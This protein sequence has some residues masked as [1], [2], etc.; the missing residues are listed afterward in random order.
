MI[1]S[2]TDKNDTLGKTALGADTMTGKKGA[3]TY[4]VNNIG[5]KVVESLDQGIDRVISSIS[6]TLA[7]NVE[8]LVLTGTAAVDGTGNKLNN[9]IHGNSGNNNLFGGAGGSDTLYGLAGSDFLYGRDGTDKLIGGTGADAYVIDVATDTIIELPKQG[10]D[11]VYSAVDYT[12]GANLE[13]LVLRLSAING[14]GNELNNLLVGNAGANTLNGLAGNDILSGKAGNDALNGGDGNDV[15]DGGE[16][17]DILTG[18]LGKD[19]YNLAETTHS[20]DTVVVGLNTTPLFLD[21]YIGNT[22]VVNGFV[23]GEDKLDA[24]FTTIVA[25]VA[26]KTAGSNNPGDNVDIGVFAQHTVSKGIYTL[27]NAAGTLVP[28]TTLNEKQ[29]YGYLLENTPLNGSIA[30]FHVSN[31]AGK[32]TDTIIMQHDH[33]AA[34]VVENHIAVDLV[35]VETINGLSATGGAG[36]VWII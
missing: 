6:Y 34:P 36:A 35:G 7:N 8:N 27:Y 2:G 31:A 24:A 25:D 1:I 12:L 3:D 11:R 33:S 21:N 23:L 4:Y 14:T 26:T 18:G 30:G 17:A 10:I 29:A 28:I 5:D 16:G 20:A 13:N 22:D 32:V 9:V 15:L 19:T